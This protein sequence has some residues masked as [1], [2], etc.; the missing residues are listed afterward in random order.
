MRANFC[1]FAILVAVLSIMGLTLGSA[2][3][4]A[5]GS[6]ADGV[7]N[8]NTADVKQ[9][10]LLPGIGLS[11]AKAI[12]EYRAKQRF[13]SPE[14]LTKVKGIG[15]GLLEKIRSRVT[16]NGQTTAKAPPKKKRSKRKK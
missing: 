8:I 11:K 13:G 1:K 9:L 16:V 3:A 12:V 15:K 6:K 7:V 4:A 5:A 14:D 10:Q 2:P